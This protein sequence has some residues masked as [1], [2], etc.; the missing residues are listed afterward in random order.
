MQQRDLEERQQ[1][2][3]K[4]VKNRVEA[5]EVYSDSLMKK[6]LTEEVQDRFKYAI[7][8]NYIQIALAKYSLGYLLAEIVSDVEN[9]YEWFI[10]RK[11]LIGECKSLDGTDQ[12]LN[13]LSLLLLLDRLEEKKEILINK[14]A[15]HKL[16]FPLVNYILQSS[17]PIKLPENWSKLE[18]KYSELI[19]AAAEKES[20]KACVKLKKYLSGWY[21]SRRSAHWWGEHASTSTIGYFG[22]W[23]F[24]AAAVAKIRNL[25]L[26]DT[27]FGEYFPYNFFGMEEQLLK[28]KKIGKKTTL[29]SKQLSATRFAYPKLPKLTFDIGTVWINESK[30]RLG[31]ITPDEELECAGTVYANE[32]VSFESFVQNRHKALLKQMPWYKL[33][34]GSKI[35]SLPIGK[36]NEQ[37]MQGIWQGESEPTSYLVYALAFDTYFMGLTFTCMAKNQKKY[38]PLI[39]NLLAS[40]RYKI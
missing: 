15:A 20:N 9:S 28:E 35:R 30:E 26:T 11:R 25:D 36:V 23:C 6:E 18:L 40:I 4:L 22:Y 29:K 8:S 5:I 13:L 31:L 16:S 33:I 37:L 12:F 17:L 14:L 10:K 24:T 38:K 3:E 27:T 1:L 7:Y 32:G 2:L 39:E 21:K 34:G 19:E